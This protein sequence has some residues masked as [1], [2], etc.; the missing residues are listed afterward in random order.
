LISNDFGNNFIEAVAERYR[1]E[2]I[3]RKRGVHFGDDGNESRV[4]NLIHMT[5]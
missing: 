5:N 2:I 3:E 1:H 4:D